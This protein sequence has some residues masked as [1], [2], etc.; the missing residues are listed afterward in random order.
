[1]IKKFLAWL[2]FSSKDPQKVSLT[3]KAALTAGLTVI[4]TTLAFL[5]IENVPS[6]DLQYVADNIVLIVN[7]ILMT[8]SG[9]VGLYGVLRKLYRTLVGENKVVNEGK[10]I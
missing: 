9:V 4:G 6:A 3:V 10:T 8:V 1:M 2:V 5:G 7:A